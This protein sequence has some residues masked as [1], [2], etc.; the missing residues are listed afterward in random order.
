MPYDCENCGKTGARMN[1]TIQ[2]RLC[3]ECLSQDYKLI[4]KSTAIKKYKLTNNE[5]INDYNY[6]KF[7][8]VNPHYKCASE[9]HLYYEKD[10]INFFLETRDNIITNILCINEPRKNIEDTVLA[11]DSYY[12]NLLTN[13]KQE[14]INQIIKK[15]KI[16]ITDYP[17]DVQKELNNA[18]SA[19]SFEFIIKKYNRKKELVNTL[20]LNKLEKY[21][22]L[23]LCLQ[24]INCEN[25][26]SLN[27][28]IQFIFNSL[29]K[30]RLIKEAIKLYSIPKNKYDKKINKFINCPTKKDVNKF[31]K[32]IIE[33]ENRYS[34]LEE[35]LKSRGLELRSDSKLCNNFLQGSNEY[36]IDEIVDIMEQ[37]NWFFTHTD[38]SSYCNEFSSQRRNYEYDYYYD[39][40]EYNEERSKY[41]KNKAITHWIQNPTEPHPPKSLNS[42]IEQIK[43]KLQNKSQKAKCNSTQI[44]CF[45]KECSNYG[46]RKCAGL[47]CRICCNCIVCQ[48]HKK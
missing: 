5:L 12:K 28:I 20:K 34:S 1:T 40:D 7:T 27:E 31:I 10:I 24:Y 42:F 32:K 18:K 48:I 4:C 23:L 33:K 30:K 46:S 3:S 29:E 6:E 9:M 19:S 47:F 2:K 44:N 15:K 43:Q 16:E 8:T 35:K 45:N 41:A 21:S 38:Y 11:V 17:P 13:K 26:Y 25:E 36:S 14:K 39:K 37:M 22:T